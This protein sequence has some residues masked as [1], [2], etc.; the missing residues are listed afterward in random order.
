MAV[1]TGLMAAGFAKPVAGE[2]LITAVSSDTVS[3]K[4]TFTGAEI[5]LFGTIERDVQTVARP[6]GYDI[7]IVTR[8]PKQ[9][10]VV[11][12]KSRLAGIWVNR[13]SR[14]YVNAPSYLA[15][16]SNRPL[17]EIADPLVLSRFQLSLDQLTLLEPGTDA[18]AP[19]PQATVF[20]EA[21][22][23][24]M[25][26]RAHY[27]EDPSGVTFLSPA[28]FKANIPLPASVPVGEY[29]AEVYLLGDGALLAQAAK[30]ISIRKAGVEQL[31]T[32]LASEMPLFYGL[33]AV[34]LAIFSGWLAGIVFRRD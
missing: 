25:R 21:L 22:L 20:Q 10:I 6:R 30:V 18:A 27:V 23:R 17:A 11:R 4:S 19:A 33:L 3:I 9:R 14:D 31:V 28:L 24:L 26:R 32:V 8:G 13:E 7:V 5:V 34:A 2:E 15:I 12:R 29:R 16:L 1:L